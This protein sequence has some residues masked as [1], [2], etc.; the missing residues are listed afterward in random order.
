MNKLFCIELKTL[1]VAVMIGS[2]VFFSNQLAV[3]QPLYKAEGDKVDKCLAESK[4]VLR[5]KTSADF[6]DSLLKFGRCK[7]LEWQPLVF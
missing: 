6:I 1:P 7:R 4:L 3:A 2:L 5:A